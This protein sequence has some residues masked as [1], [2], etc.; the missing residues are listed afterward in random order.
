MQEVRI[1]KII[2]QMSLTN[3]SVKYFLPIILEENLP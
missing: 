1:S 2:N 3:E